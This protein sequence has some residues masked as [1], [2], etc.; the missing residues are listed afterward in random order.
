MKNFSRFSILAAVLMAFAGSAVAVDF[1]FEATV[2]IVAGFE[3]AE[4]QQLNFGVLAQEDGTVAVAAAD[5]TFSG[6]NIVFDSANV[7]QGVFTVTA[8]RGA[9]IQ[10]ACREGVAVPGLALTLFTGSWDGGAE[11]PAVV[12]TPLTFT[13]P[14]GLSTSVLEIGASITVTALTVSLGT[15]IAIPFIMDVAFQ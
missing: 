8:P 9:D 15:A 10:V 5:G 12:A 3:V 13:T 11:A 2:D 7:A 6:D 4:T 14:G 1:P